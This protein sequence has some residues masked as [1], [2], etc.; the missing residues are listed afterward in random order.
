MKPALPFAQQFAGRIALGTWTQIADGDLIDMLGSAGFDFTI[1]DCEH[2]ALGVS[3]LPAL[4]RAC[5]AAG[6]VPWARAPGADGAW[7]GRALDTGVRGIVVPGAES[8]S[9]LAAVV[10]ATRYAPAGRRGAC[11]IVRS[12][13]HLV[14]DWAAYAAKEDAAV[15]V[16]ALVETPA[17]VAAAS[18]LC[19]VPGLAAVMLGPFDLSVAMDMPGQLAAPEVTGALDQVIAAARSRGLP[20][21]V[22]V[23]STDAAELGRQARH[24]L[25][26]GASA[27]TV[28]ADKLFFMTAA[29]AGLRAASAALPAHVRSHAA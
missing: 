4:V 6:L 29:V 9:A 25:G 13:G 20:V 22:P 10:A 8:A 14:G 28:G 24:W 15:G 19:G 7:A 26:R 1:L 2:G 21:I 27:L 16:V 17:G 3:G 12:G 23:F 18:E 5:E 11:P